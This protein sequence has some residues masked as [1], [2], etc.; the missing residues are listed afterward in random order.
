MSLIGLLVGPKP[1]CVMRA[2]DKLFVF[3]DPNLLHA[4]LEAFK[5]S[6]IFHEASNSYCLGDVAKGT[7]I[8]P[9]ALSTSPEKLINHIGKS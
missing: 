2:Q 6:P 7:F 5:L 4:A 1:D 8:A 3:A 9:K